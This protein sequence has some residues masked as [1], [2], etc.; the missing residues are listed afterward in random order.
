MNEILEETILEKKVLEA[1]ILA[2]RQV[3]ELQNNKKLLQLYDKHFFNID[4][5]KNGK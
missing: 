4:L 1:K 3:I 2:F 5:N